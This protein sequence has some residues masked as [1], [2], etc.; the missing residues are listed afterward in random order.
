MTTAQAVAQKCAGQL[1]DPPFPPVCQKPHPE[2][3]LM[4]K[5]PGQKVCF[6][7]Q[8]LFIRQCLSKMGP[9]HA[10]YK[11]LFELRNKR[12]IREV[13]KNCLKRQSVARKGPK[14]VQKSDLP[15][16]FSLTCREWNPKHLSWNTMGV[17]L[18]G[19]P[20]VSFAWAFLSTNHV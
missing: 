7:K 1:H 19:D 3:G 9:F 15:S 11:S 17:T 4:S 6:E 12:P 10:C 5:G 20:L 18:A 2:R 14:Q 13:V 16:G 8:T